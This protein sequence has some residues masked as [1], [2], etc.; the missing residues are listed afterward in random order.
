MATGTI[1]GKGLY[2]EFEPTE[3]TGSARIM[4][5]LFTPEGFDE[6]GNYAPFSMHSRTVADYSPRKQWRVTKCGTSNKDLLTSGEPVG[7][8]TAQELAVAMTSRFQEHLERAIST[9]TKEELVWK[10]RAKP[11]AVEVTSF[12]LQEVNAYKTPS[13]VLRRIQ[14]CRLGLALPEKLV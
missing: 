3:A 8:I 5:V 2:L 7:Q 11:I 6:D 14:K 4:Q 13:P 9:H 10:L 1:V 12:D